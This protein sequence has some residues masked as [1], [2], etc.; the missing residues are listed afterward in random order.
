MPAKTMPMDVSSLIPVRLL[1]RPISNAMAI[2][3]GRAAR[4]GLIPSRNATTMPGRTEWAS[5]SP[6]NA[7]PR[8]MT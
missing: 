7:R 6:M 2:P 3:A 1:T 8:V 4:K 5:A